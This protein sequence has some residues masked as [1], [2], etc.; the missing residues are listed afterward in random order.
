MEEINNILLNL[1][2]ALQKKDSELMEYQNKLAFIFVN[3]RKHQDEPDLQEIVK[4][5]LKEAF[6]QQL[7]EEH[8]NTFKAY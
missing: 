1:K 6:E 2:I 5:I 3:L 7:T 4:A 8:G